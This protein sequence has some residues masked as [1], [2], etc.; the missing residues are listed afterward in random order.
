MTYH[1]ALDE[2]STALFGEKY[3]ENVRVLKIGRPPVSMELCGGTHVAATGEIG[4]FHILTESGIGAGL[5]RIEAVT[6]R[7]AEA[8]I[9]GQF[10]NLNKIKELVG[11]V[12][13]A[14]LRIRLTVWLTALTRRRSVPW[15]WN[16]RFQR[17]PFSLC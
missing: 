17:K 7:E 1:Q 4:F 16:A 14:K 12:R 3:G 2:G 6:G 5:R 9:T 11:A 15:N 8:F 10:E 13:P